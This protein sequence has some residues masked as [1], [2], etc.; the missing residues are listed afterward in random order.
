MLSCPEAARNILLDPQSLQVVANLHSGD[1]RTDN[2]FALAQN[3]PG[4]L[5]KPYEHFEP[6]RAWIVAILTDRARPLWHRLLLLGSFCQKL[7]VVTP[8]EADTLVPALLADYY[9]IVGTAWGAAEMKAA[10]PQPRLK[11]NVL[12]RLTS[13]FTE[14]PDCGNRFRNTYLQFVEGIAANEQGTDLERLARA[15]VWYQAYFDGAP[16]V[17]ENYLFNYVFQHLF[18][19]GRGGSARHAPQTIFDEYLLLATQFAWLT[20]LL[21]GVAGTHGSAF[22]DGHVIHTV[23]SFCREVEH[24]PTLP[25]TLLDFLRTN[26]LDNMA[27]MAALLRP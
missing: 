25:V 5:Y 1:F 10:P 14:A 11:L 20:G 17:L 16:H 7:A 24:N 2:Y 26:Q 4:V 23:Q 9:Q 13:Y 22:A 3:A 21:T 27:A 12:L 8:T 6:V 18:P 15:H 19:F